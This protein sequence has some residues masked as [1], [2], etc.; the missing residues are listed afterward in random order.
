MSESTFSQDDREPVGCT[1]Q[2][3]IHQGPGA[4]IK[5]NCI[6]IEVETPETVAEAGRELRGH[7]GAVSVAG[8]NEDAVIQAL[9]RYGDS[10]IGVMDNRANIIKQSTRYITIDW[11][12]SAARLRIFRS[13]GG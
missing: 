2:C 4:D 12:M 8:T 1:L 6:T 5:A 3:S 9:E 13:L 11:M 10:T 7:R